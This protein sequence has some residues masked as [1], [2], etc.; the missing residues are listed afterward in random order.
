MAC[1][2]AED[3]AHVVTHVSVPCSP[4]GQPAWLEPAAGLFLPGPAGTTIGPV[5]PAA[6]P[7]KGMGTRTGLRTRWAET[8]PVSGEGDRDPPPRRDPEVPRAALPGGFGVGTVMDFGTG[9]CRAVAR[10]SAARPFP[11]HGTAQPLLPRGTARLLLPHSQ[12][13][14]MPCRAGRPP[15]APSPSL[16]PKAFLAPPP[17][18][19]L[20]PSHKPTPGRGLA[21]RQRSPHGGG[22]Q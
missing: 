6:V 12:S 19:P 22:G 11:P 21:V 1:H 10:P 13:R 15:Y 20:A 2:L 9:S 18:H 5:P 8:S 3:R 16:L 7:A 4:R 17:P 14:T